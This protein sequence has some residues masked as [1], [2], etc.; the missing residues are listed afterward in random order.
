M[1]DQREPSVVPEQAGR[2]DTVQDMTFFEHLEALK[3]HLVRGVMALLVATVLAFLAK[4]FIIDRVLLGPQSAGFPT[5]RFFCWLAGLLDTPSL[6]INR[7]ELNMINT[8]LA[9]QFNLHMTVS[10]VV[11]LVIAVP[12]LLWELWRFIRP[13]LT[14]FEQ[15]RSRLFVLYVSACFFTGLLFGYYIIAPLSINFLNNYTASPQIANFIDVNSYLSSV[16]NVSI[17]AAVLFELPVL[18]YFLA[19]M[20]ILR[21]AY[22]KKYRRHALLVLAVFSAVITPPDVFS[23]VLL[24]LPLY[25]LYEFS[26][27]IAEGVERRREAREAVQEETA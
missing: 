8:R 26:I 9:G 1:T 7:V 12:Y 5:N 20:G 25:G 13:A 14:A 11:G 27:R 10:F 16:L 4:N 18:V 17:A 15:K 3:P 21:S 6:C 19:R 23:L 24:L 2:E 22:M